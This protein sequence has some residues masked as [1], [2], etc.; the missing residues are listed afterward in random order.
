VTQNQPAFAVTPSGI[1]MTDRVRIDEVVAFVRSHDDHRALAAMLPGMSRKHHVMVSAHCRFAHAAALVFPARLA[2]ARD[3]LRACGLAPGEIWPSVVVRDRLGR[4]YGLDKAPDVGIVHAPIDGD[5][6]RRREIELFLL[7]AAPGTE[8]EK[9]AQDER[10]RSWETHIAFDVTTPD[11]VVLSGLHA[12]LT[13]PGCLSR[14]GGGY[15][16]H[17]DATMLYF[18][19]DTAS[20]RVAQRLELRA[21][22]RHTDILRTHLLESSAPLMPGSCRVCPHAGDTDGDPADRLLR[23]MTGAWTTQAIAVAAELSLADHLARNPGA[24]SERLAELTAADPDCLDRLLRYLGS[25]GILRTNGGAIQLTDLGHLLRSDADHSLHALARIYGGSFYQSFG[26]LL[27]TVRTGQQGFEHVFGDHHFD[28]FAQR[29]HLGFDQA[30]AASS[31]M[32]S[33]L[34]EIIDFST[35]RVV[36]D[37]AGGNG[38]LLG[39]VLEATPHLRGVLLERP[40]V[41]EAARGNLTRLG[42]A[43]R[44]ELVAGNFTTTVPGGGDVYVLSRVLH[45]WDDEQALHILRNCA[46]AMPEHGELL[47]IER[48][49]PENESPSLAAAWDIHMMCNV[50]GRERTAEHYGRLLHDAGF[51]VTGQHS[52]PLDAALL[53]VRHRGHAGARYG[54]ASIAE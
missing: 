5:D 43:D 15:N 2:D 20:S 50:G 28:Y 25:L 45:D 16:G 4:R 30:M 32:F 23:L 21:A 31:A 3:D 26:A 11:P 24:R 49:L 33:S 41:I 7:A 47:I 48:L 35:V 36:V 37:V 9:I 8:E 46:A 51:E 44:C 18:R 17:E 10:V 13:G 53:H 19:N 34:A 54:V 52:L 6:G 22:G 40:H 38:E 39:K 12:I 42:C 14:D 29:P 27:H 1:N